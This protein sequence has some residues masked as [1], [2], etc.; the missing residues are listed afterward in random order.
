M[1][2]E[3]I[4]KIID[5]MKEPLQEYWVNEALLPTGIM[6]RSMAI[7]DLYI[8]ERLNETFGDMKIC[9]SCRL[10]DGTGRECLR[11]AL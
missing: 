4:Q 11:K 5:D 7:M 1:N 6:I 9:Y 10:I 3:Q 2:K 8:H